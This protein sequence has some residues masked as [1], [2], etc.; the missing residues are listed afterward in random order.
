MASNYTGD[1][2]A[3]QAPA[4]A[5]GVGVAPIVVLPDDPDAF[6]AAA[7]YQAYKTLA[8]YTAF[9]LRAGGGS[10]FQVNDE[11][12]GDDLISHKWQQLVSGSG[13]ALS[14]ID[15]NANGGSGAL[16]QSVGSSGGDA[17]IFTRNLNI[18]TAN[19]GIYGRVR[20]VT[21]Q[22]FKLGLVSAT[23][24]ENAYFQHITG[25]WWWIL[26]AGNGD[27]GVSV[28]STYQKLEIV[29]TNGVASFRI[30]GTEYHS[31]AMSTSIAAG[32]LTSE[33]SVG[34]VA[35][36]EFRLDKLSMWANT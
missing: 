14:V 13:S 25:T 8:D 26:G 1:P 21:A 10:P 31:G 36:A 33:C 17:T 35:A 7:F 19:F 3:V 20:A 30:D 34:S 22:S 16:Q 5:P 12:L 4:S 11:F 23:T 28:A 9:V 29:R 18:G 24:A 15:D 6:N 27:T 2:T 32:I